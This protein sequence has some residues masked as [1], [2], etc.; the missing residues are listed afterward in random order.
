MLQLNLNALFSED[1]GLKVAKT[2]W[3]NGMLMPSEACRLLFCL[4]GGHAKATSGSLGH[5]SKD[6]NWIASGMS[7]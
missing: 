1:L 5:S 2:C 7:V 6:G 4:A 3:G